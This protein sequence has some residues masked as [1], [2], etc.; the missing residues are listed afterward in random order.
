VPEMRGGVN[1]FNL[2]VGVAKHFD[3][4]VGEDRCAVVVTD[5]SD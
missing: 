3:G 1:C 4:T 2:D 5:F